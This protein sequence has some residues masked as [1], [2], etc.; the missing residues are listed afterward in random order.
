MVRLPYS[1]GR[2]P[3]RTYSEGLT[4]SSYEEPFA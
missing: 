2:A 4:L 1:R 3:E